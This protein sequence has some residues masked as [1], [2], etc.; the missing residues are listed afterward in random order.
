L[1][2]KLSM[3]GKPVAVLSD[4]HGNRWALLA[5]LKDIDR[6][7]I[8]RVVNLG[9]SLYGPLDPLGTAQI[10]MEH[11]MPTVRGNEDRILIAAWPGE[12]RSPALVYVRDRLAAEH[13]EWLEALE[14]STTAYGDFFLCHGTP[15]RDDEYLLQ[16]VTDGGVSL[17]A[18]GEVEKRVGMLEQPVVLCGHDHVARSMRL[19]DGKLIVNPGSVGLPA[20]R[21]DVPYPHVMEAGSPHARY[22][23]VCRCEGVWQVEEQIVEYD[24]EVAA[25]MALKNGRLDWA[26]WLRSGMAVA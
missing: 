24:W 21:D 14:T 13:I 11:K 3:I 4:I 26:E 7:G 9:D 17:R 19:P 25:G 5:V 8:D 22:S 6:R 2:I 16:K 12:A 15:D 1:V 23:I 10:L 20:Y 18:T